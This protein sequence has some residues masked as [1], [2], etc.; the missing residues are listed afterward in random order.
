MRLAA[1]ALLL[2]GCIAI[3]D[4]DRY[5]ELEDA[6]SVGCSAGADCDDGL[7]C[8]DDRCVAGECARPV[9]SGYCLID[10]ACMT[11]GTPS[12][13]DPCHVCGEASATD[14]SVAAGASCDDGSECTQ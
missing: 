11:A 14:W 5:A 2:T 6:G 12:S 9:A 3:N 10:G 8:T 1:S 13:E 4:Y 7:D